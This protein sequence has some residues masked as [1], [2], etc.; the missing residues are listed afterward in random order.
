MGDSIVVHSEHGGEAPTLRAEPRVFNT[1]ST[2]Y[3]ASGKV[4]LDGV[5]YQVSCNV[6]KIESKPAK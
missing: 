1:G 3:F 2:L 5:K 6:V 4:T